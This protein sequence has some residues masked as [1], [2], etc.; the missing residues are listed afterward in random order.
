MQNTGLHLCICGSCPFFDANQL[1]QIL[2]PNFAVSIQNN[3]N[4]MTIR[5]YT[6]ELKIKMMENVQ[7]LVIGDVNGT[8]QMI[9]MDIAK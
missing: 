5:H 1:E 4:L 9:Y 3:C 8:F 2:Q 7:V 6:N